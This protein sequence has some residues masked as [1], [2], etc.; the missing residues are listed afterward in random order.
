M[1]KTLVLSVGNTNSRYGIFLKGSLKSSGICDSAALRRLNR[2]DFEDTFLVSVNRKNE[3]RLRCG[4]K[5]LAIKKPGKRD[6]FSSQYD[7]KLLGMDRF[8]STAKCICENDYPALIID[9][10]TAD[11]FDFIDSKGVH[12]GGFIT[13]G[14]TTMAKSLAKSTDAL[15]ETEPQDGGLRIGRN[16]D[17]AISFGIYNLWLTGILSV[18]AMFRRQERR[19]KIIVCGGNSLKLKDFLPDAVIDADYLLKAIYSYGKRIQSM[20]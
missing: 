1:S 20:Q 7:V 2:G 16:T 4:L 19:G 13:P 6:C 11:T 15:D 10:G 8:V 9:T 17:E 12:N 3:R 5:G 18:C 14:L